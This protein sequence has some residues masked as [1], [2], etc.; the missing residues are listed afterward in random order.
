MNR[1]LPITLACLVSALAGC[2]SMPAS[3]PTVAQFEDNARNDAAGIKVIEATPAILQ[4]ANRR[5]AVTGSIGGV[6][7]A[8]G[9]AD[10]IGPDDVLQITVFEIGPGLFSS[11][12]NGNSTSSG[13]GRSAVA[14]QLP[15]V[16]VG[17]DGEITIPYVGRV[18]A[19]GLT[20]DQ[21]RARLEGKLAKL[22]SQPKVAVVLANNL[23]GTVIVSGDAQTPGR[24]TLTQ[25]PMRLLDVI[26]LAG[27]GK[28]SP[29]DTLVTL[30]R[31][32][33]QQK[34]RLAAIGPLTPTNP[35][36]RPGDRVHLAYE[37]QTYTV[38]GA[39]PKP[40]E[41][42]FETPSITLA[43]ALARTGGL[44][45]AK[46]DPQGVY[47]F[48]Y[49]RPEVAKR[50]GMAVTGWETAPVI[51]HFNMLDPTHYFVLQKFEVRDQDL[52]YVANAR[53]TQVRK[54]LE[55]LSAMF[56]P[57]GPVGSISNL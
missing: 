49:E 45:D 56:S 17:A 43:Q 12:T 23:A 22:A 18:K 24:Y 36:L 51:Y 35:V 55:L 28:H 32:S 47:L 54:F 39:S 5:E 41:V 15:P 57:L 16:T 4:V 38:F 10:K 42:D 29:G 11:G 19:A 30:V 20:A 53:A 3:G 13:L 33:K 50:L 46:A 37:P 31:G 9:A 2:T 7:K 26:A 40:I 27:S 34:A 14:T 52:L 1:A 25:T 8:R 44:N 6:P 48:R 21:L